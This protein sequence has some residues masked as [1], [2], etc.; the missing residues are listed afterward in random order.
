[1][2]VLPLFHMSIEY[3]YDYIE[4]NLG[5]D[6]VLPD[7]VWSGSRNDVTLGGFMLELYYFGGSHGVGMT[8]FLLPHSRQCVAQ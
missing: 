6:Q 5:P 8:A 1:M 3:A 2:L 4:A 7:E